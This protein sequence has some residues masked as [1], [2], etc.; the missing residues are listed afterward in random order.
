MSNMN[1]CVSSFPG[2]VET[3][4]HAVLSGA[5]VQVLWEPY[6][7]STDK[8]LYRSKLFIVDSVNFQE[9][10]P[11]V[12]GSIY[13]FS[14]SLYIE[15]VWMYIKIDS[16]GYLEMLLS[17]TSAAT[18]ESNSFTW[19]VQAVAGGCFQRD[20]L[21][22]GGAVLSPAL[23]DNGALRTV[24]VSDAISVLG[25]ASTIRVVS[26]LGTNGTIAYPSF[27]IETSV[28]EESLYSMASWIPGL[29][30]TYMPLRIQ[31]FHFSSESSNSEVC[32]ELNSA[33][34]SYLN[35]FQ[36]D[37][38]LTKTEV[39]LDPC[40]ELQLSVDNTGSILEGSL[41]KL[42]AAIR[43][44]ARVLFLHNN[45]SAERSFEAEKIRLYY[46]GSLD[47][48]STMGIS[49]DK[50]YTWLPVVARSDGR[51]IA[52]GKEATDSE[53]RK[54]YTDRRERSFRYSQDYYG[55]ELEGTW[56]EAR[57][58]L[59]SG[60]MPRA[61]VG[62][63]STYVIY[64]EIEAVE[65]AFQAPA[66]YFRSNRE[67]RGDGFLVYYFNLYG[68]I[69]ADVGMYRGYGDEI[70]PNG[71]YDNVTLFFEDYPLNPDQ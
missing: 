16:S 54:F 2:S 62:I 46:G 15:P 13:T 36:K 37:P 3:L 58:R 51:W 39:F 68:D 23:T 60:L 20:V 26:H 9:Y 27:A 61:M 44:G 71:S 59:K 55:N 49:Q 65:L 45:G 21:S 24:E 50:G 17:N 53:P 47:A 38:A 67:P 56:E 5:R 41:E 34:G 8:Y 70:I 29:G 35:D 12:T 66:T 42:A 63:N 4:R 52:G 22:H 10:A 19:L 64:L 7:L 6:P 57:E 32:I 1:G 48:Y 28:G 30:G 40:W 25:R 69:R 11:K 31:E 33:N 14:T 43:A 18:F